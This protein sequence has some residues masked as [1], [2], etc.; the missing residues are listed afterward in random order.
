MNED[1]E[2]WKAMANLQLPHMP[3]NLD[4]R[5]A[6][7]RQQRQRQPQ[8][9]AATTTTTWQEQKHAS[10]P[11]IRI[12][13]VADVDLSSSAALAEYF[14]QQQQQQKT[15]HHQQQQQF[16]G[17]NGHNLGRS[18]GGG[19]GGMLDSSR[20]DL[21]IA[22]G[23][24]GREEDVR[25]YMTGS[26]DKSF[27][28]NSRSTRASA[29]SV[30]SKQ[31]MSTSTSTTPL[32]VPFS[33]SKEET[34]G[35]EGLLTA[36]LSQ[37]EAIVCRVVYCP[38]LSD[39]ITTMVS[40]P[41]ASS[42]PDNKINHHHQ[43]GND[44]NNYRRNNSKSYHRRL[45]PNSRNIHKQWL[46]LA[47]ALG[48]AGLLYLESTHAVLSSSKAHRKSRRRKLSDSSDDDEGKWTDDD[49]IEFLT[50]KLIDSQKSSAGYLATLSRLLQMAPPPNNPLPFATSLSQSILVTH[51]VDF[52]SSSSS[53][54]DDSDHVHNNNRFHRNGSKSRD[55]GD[56]SSKGESVNGPRTVVDR[57]Y[58][59]WPAADDGGHDGFV[60]SQAAQTLLCLEIASGS[61]AHHPAHVEKQ[62]NVHILFPGSLRTRGDF[63]VVELSVST[64]TSTASSSTNSESPRRSREF[65][66]EEPPKAK[67]TSEANKNDLR[68]ADI[69]NEPNGAVQFLWKVTNVEFHNMH[70]DS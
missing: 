32:E 60:Q 20:I 26:T 48:C 46:P 35:L 36:A 21:C 15:H 64:K 17:Q 63:A 18:K 3:S 69:S 34:S 9:H 29:A 58:L 67:D 14:L 28:G 4:L 31:T 52:K 51:Y 41:L 27:N 23:P 1:D 19:D 30:S 54:D 40:L 33:R 2:I 50:E 49:E 13:V 37:L 62:G 5:A 10:L 25:P 53:L 12:L 6:Q 68:G 8:E 61:S 42:L 24:F 57:H 39:P 44:Q 16:K 38:G 43:N 45:T 70:F 65:Q 22:C 66:K 59:P 47:P 7:Q 11:S 55:K 56:K